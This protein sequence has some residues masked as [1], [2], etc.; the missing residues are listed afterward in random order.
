MSRENWSCRSS[1]LPE[2]FYCSVLIYNGK[3]HVHG[4]KLIINLESLLVQGD[5]DPKEQIDE[6]ASDLENC[7]SLTFVTQGER[8]DIKRS[9]FTSIFLSIV[10]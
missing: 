5:E 3:T 7:W 10:K 2:F 6:R 1:I 9:G 4:R 8:M